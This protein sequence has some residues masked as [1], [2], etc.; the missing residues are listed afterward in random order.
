MAARRLNRRAPLN[1]QPSGDLAPPRPRDQTKVQPIVADRDI[2]L[3]LCVLPPPWPPCPAPPPQP[4]DPFYLA[5]LA[6]TGG[7]S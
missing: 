4:G 2:A 6:E 7:T 1:G 3:C 5:W